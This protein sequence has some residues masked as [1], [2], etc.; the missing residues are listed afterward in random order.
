METVE[1]LLYFWN[2]PIEIMILVEESAYVCKMIKKQYVLEYIFVC[3]FKEWKKITMLTLMI[4]ALYKHKIF[5][6]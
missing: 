4:N 1:E 3:K 2:I 6:R 5:F